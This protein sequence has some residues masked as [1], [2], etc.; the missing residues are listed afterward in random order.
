MSIY[1]NFCFSGNCSVN[2]DNNITLTKKTFSRTVSGKNWKNKPDTITTEKVNGRY[3]QNYVR[4]IPFFNNFGGQSS[5]RASWN[6]TKK[7]YIPVTVST[8]SP[9]GLTKIVTDFC[10]D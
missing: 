6:Y 7:G 5:C 1:S 2:A 3:Y 9:D 4:S 8:V 10:F